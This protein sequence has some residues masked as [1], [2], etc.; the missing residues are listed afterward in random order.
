MSQREPSE[1]AGK[2]VTLRAEA[3][4]LGGKEIRIE[5]W[6]INIAGI[7]WG[8]ANGNPAALK[9]AFRAGLAGIPADNEVLYGKVEGLGHLV[10][11]SEIEVPA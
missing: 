2:T 5:D 10:H 1:Y 9:Y 4:G 6:W 7:P 8:N 3:R 11:I